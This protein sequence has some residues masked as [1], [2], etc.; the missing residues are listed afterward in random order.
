[1][2]RSRHPKAA[3]VLAAVA[4]GSVV[5]SSCSSSKSS[6]AGS[7][8]PIKVGAIATLS[9]SFTFTG[10]ID[11]AK[12][13]FSYLNAHGGI[14]G[15]TV[16]YMVGDD[17]GTPTRATQLAKQQV[18]AGIVGMAASTSLAECDVNGPYYKQVGIISVNTGP[19]LTCYNSPNIGPLEN[20]PTSTITTAL[21]YGSNVLNLSKVCVIGFNIPG[22]V[23]NVVAG[24]KAWETLTGKTLALDTTALNPAADPTPGVL[25]AKAAGCQFVMAPGQQSQGLELIKDA[26]AQGIP[27]VKWVL[28]PLVYNPTFIPAA[29]AAASAAITDSDVAPWTDTSNSFVAEMSKEMT[30]SDTQLGFESEAGY[31]AAWVMAQALKAIKG[32]ITRASVTAYFTSMAP[33]TVPDMG[34]PYTFGSGSTHTPQ[35]PAFK[36]VGIS[37]GNFSVLTLALQDRLAC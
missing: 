16:D 4:I 24:V 32:P 26:E 31:T 6:K 37:N 27:D 20:S 34:Q 1:M 17:G 11:G 13:Y 28:G 2:P 33:M 9:G 3:A 22:E 5:L 25:Q 12:A 14:N 19:N 30:A 29:G 35:S 10:Y 18:A 36:Y 8:G 23:P 15:R 7:S 21:Y